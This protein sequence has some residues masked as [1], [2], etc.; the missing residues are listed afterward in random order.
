MNL[1]LIE[2]IFCLP[3]LYYRAFTESKNTACCAVLSLVILL[4]VPIF[5]GILISNKKMVRTALFLQAIFGSIAVVIYGWWP[6]GIL[7]LTILMAVLYYWAI[8]DFPLA[9]LD[10]K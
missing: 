9:S 4:I 7:T 5:I 8:K 10:T 1:N 2:I 6:L 3:W